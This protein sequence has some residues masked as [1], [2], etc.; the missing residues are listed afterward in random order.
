M[1]EAES[2]CLNS[3]FLNLNHL[4]ILTLKYERDNGDLFD[5]DR[6]LLRGNQPSLAFFNGSVDS[7]QDNP[8]MLIKPC[9]TAQ[10]ARC[11]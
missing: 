5:S 6:D 2:G 3:K 7:F 4:I 9:P 1:W 11:K 8:E 10:P